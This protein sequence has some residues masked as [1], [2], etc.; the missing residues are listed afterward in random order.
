MR[1]AVCGL[2]Y[3]V[4]GMGYTVWATVQLYNFTTLQLYP[5]PYTASKAIIALN[6][7]LNSG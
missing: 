5:I 4:S 2:R 6:T 3:P 1:Q 7:K